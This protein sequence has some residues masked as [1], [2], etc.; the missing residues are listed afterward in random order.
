[1]DGLKCGEKKGFSRGELEIEKE[2]FCQPCRHLTCQMECFQKL[3]SSWR[4]PMERGG[5]AGRFDS[6]G[7]GGDNFVTKQRTCVNFRGLLPVES[8]V[9]SVIQ[10]S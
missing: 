3:D 5:P 10:L 6:G 4:G 9:I 1:M 2:A 8:A 7:N